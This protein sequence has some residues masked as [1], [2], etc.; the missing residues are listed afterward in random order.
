MKEPVRAV[1]TESSRSE[2]MWAEAAV[3]AMY[4]MSR[5]PKEGLDVTPCEALTC[6][7]PDVSGLAVWGSTAQALK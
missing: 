5:L 3:A 1:L 7:R 2:D 4:V 6:E